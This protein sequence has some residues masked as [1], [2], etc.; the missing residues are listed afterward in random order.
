MAEVLAGEIDR[1]GASPELTQS[2]RPGLSV[3]G[4]GNSGWVL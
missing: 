2:R 4:I 3:G 1:A